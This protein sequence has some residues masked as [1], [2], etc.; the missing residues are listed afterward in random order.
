M[1]TNSVFR[2]VNQNTAKVLGVSD[3]SV[4][5]GAQEVQWSDSGT[6]DHNWRPRLLNDG[7]VFTNVNSGKVLSIDQMMSGAGADTVQAA[8]SGAAATE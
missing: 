4:A 7:Y 5:E 1:V 2:I 8:D 6:P 3:M